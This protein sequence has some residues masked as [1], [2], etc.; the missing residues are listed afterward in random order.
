M[1]FFND[2]SIVIEQTICHREMNVNE[3]S[4]MTS[5][6]FTE[7]VDHRDQLSNATSCQEGRQ[8]LEV[9]RSLWNIELLLT[10]HPNES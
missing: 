7:M 9:Y 1:K 2:Y 10:P 5:F 8:G 3:D 4:N 6:Y